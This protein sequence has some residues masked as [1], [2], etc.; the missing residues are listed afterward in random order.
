M[1]CT[2]AS[3]RPAS[4]TACQRLLGQQAGRAR[5]RG[6]GLGDHRA[7]GADG[8]G[9]VTARDAVEGEGEIVRPEDGDAPFEG[10]VH[11]ADAAAGVDG[12]QA[13]GSGEG[14]CGR[15]TELGGG[16]GQLDFGQPGRGR[17]AGLGLGHGD[18]LA[19]AGLDAAGEGLEEGAGAGGMGILERL[20][21]GGRRLDGLGHLLRTADRV[22]LS[23]RLP[24]ARVRRLEGA[25]GPGGPP[26]TGDQDR[27]C[28]RHGV[29]SFLR[30]GLELRTCFRGW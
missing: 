1:S 20:G 10:P 15:L 18:D 16:P 25:G 9:E 19:G 21:G 6:V 29:E 27:L 24:G 5:M 4:R 13:P 22:G 14:R 7:T 23:R 2:V 30:T 28:L 8:G 12:G 26:L 3:G 11:G 17:K